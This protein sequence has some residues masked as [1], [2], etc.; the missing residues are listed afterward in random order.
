MLLHMHAGQ[1]KLQGVAAFGPMTCTCHP[2]DQQQVVCDA[3]SP[4]MVADMPMICKA[5]SLAKSNLVRESS[6]GRPRWGSLTMCS[7]SIT[8]QHSSPANGHAGS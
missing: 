3:D 5:G 4:P 1:C 8:T 2:C 6:R 7:S